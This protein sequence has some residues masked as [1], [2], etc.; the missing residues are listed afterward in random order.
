EMAGDIY[1]KVCL[2]GQRLEDMGKTLNTATDK[3]N[4][5]VTALVGKQGLYGKVERFKSA[6]PNIKGDLPTLAEQHPT[7]E[8]DRLGSL[9]SSDNSEIDTVAAQNEH[10]LKAV[11]KRQES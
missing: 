4:K 1:N 10:R 3:Y 7:L 5:T 6:A 11:D 9:T 8:H 2:V